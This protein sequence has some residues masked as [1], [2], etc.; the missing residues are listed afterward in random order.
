[1]TRVSTAYLNT[2]LIRQM[3]ESNAQVANTSYQIS[4]GYK[5]QKL[6]EISGQASSLLSLK[7]L[8]K[9]SDIYIRNIETVDARLD[10]SENALNNMQD[11]LVNASSLWTLARNENT[12]ETR[13]ALAPQAEGLLNSFYDIFQSEFDGR[14]LFSGQNASVSP[15]SGTPSAQPFGGNP[16]STTY[17]QGDS[18]LAQIITGPGTSTSYG[19]AGDNPGF[20]ELKQGLEALYY[21]LQNN[22]EVDI[23]GGIQLLEQAQR[24][25]SNMIG[26]V[27]GQKSNL[28]LQKDRYEQNQVFLQER[29]DNIDKIDVSEA[30]TRF[31]QE[32][33][34]MEASMLVI[35]QMTQVS[36][37][38]FLN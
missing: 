29:I 10:A 30:I 2:S 18:A 36:L 5:A 28:Q 13:A 15:I 31:S 7:D 17:Y 27:G 20:A 8:T 33:A 23:D 12:A 3:Q 11:L 4:S 9:Q 35:T 37:I 38:N 24:S 6:S 16:P 14:Y 32:Q 21:G 22:S 19:V 1:M 25:I 26:E 34:A